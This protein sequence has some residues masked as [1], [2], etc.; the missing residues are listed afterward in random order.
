MKTTSVVI[1]LSAIGLAGCGTLPHINCEKA[2]KVNVGMTEQEVIKLLGDPYVLQ[3]GMQ[4]G[5]MEKVLGWQNQE[6]IA[7]STNLLRVKI[8]NE[9]KVTEV[10]G[11]CEGQALGK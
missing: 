8:S 4:N 2:T 5:K 9:G 11:N 1:L 6:S 3:M 7:A 10:T